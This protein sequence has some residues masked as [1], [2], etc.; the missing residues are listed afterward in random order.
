MMLSRRQFLPQRLLLVVFLLLSGPRHV[1]FVSRV[2]DRP[3]WRVSC[4]ADEVH[5][6]ASGSLVEIW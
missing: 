5:Q 6:P 2:F 1:V 4:L 3:L